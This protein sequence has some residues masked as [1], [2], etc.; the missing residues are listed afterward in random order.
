M[1]HVPDD[2][3]LPAIL[4]AGGAARRMGG[5]DKCLRLLAG[6]PILGHVI[7]RIRPQVTAMVLNAN[8]DPARFATY[9]LAVVA[10]DIGDQPGPL[11]GIL[12]GLDWIAAHMPAA[13]FAL[14]VST[15]C[16][17]LPR[18]L[19]ARLGAALGD[20]ADIVLAASKGR[21]HPVIGLWRVTLRRDL[22]QALTVEDIHKVERFCDRHRFIAV[23][24]PAESLDP[25]FNAN[26]PADLAEA[27]QLAVHVA[28]AD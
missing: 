6:R 22:R 4:L 17:F 11:A 16:P 18:D 25:F 23:N 3:P 5:G 1:S 21:T 19:V 2:P 24:F 7:D 12:A 10:D 15:D 8:G 13:T 26:T 14:T 27:E 28:G 9:G 20:G